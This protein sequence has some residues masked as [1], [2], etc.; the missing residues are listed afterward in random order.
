MKPQSNTLGWIELG[1]ATIG[2][3]ISFF[4]RALGPVSK[5]FFRN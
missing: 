3:N 5:G 1:V 4:A 2:L